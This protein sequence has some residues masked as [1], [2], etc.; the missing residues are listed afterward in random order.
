[1]GN[2]ICNDHASTTSVSK[3]SIQSEFYRARIIG[4][5]RWRL[6]C[7]TR[8]P[9]E[10]QGQLRGM[11]D[12]SAHGLRQEL[13]EARDKLRR[14]IEILNGVSGYERSGAPYMQVQPEVEELTAT[15]QEIE[16]ALVQLEDDDA[17]G[18]P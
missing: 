10:K 17:K 15:L 3:N 11:S 12:E 16:D 2:D 6:L 13:L 9:F 4:R 1:L 18:S 14:Q 7:H 5:R 8:H